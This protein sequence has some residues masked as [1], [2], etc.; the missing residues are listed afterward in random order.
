MKIRQLPLL[1]AALSACG[2]SFAAEPARVTLP[3]FTTAESV[4][5]VCD[6]GLQASRAAIDA[7]ANQPLTGVSAASTLAA[8]DGIAMAIEDFAGPVEIA[9]NVSPVKAVRDA[10]EACS[11]KVAELSNSLFQNVEVYERIRRIDDAKG[12]AAEVRKVAI[13]GFEDAGATLPADKRKRA[14]EILDRIDVLS[15][16]FARNAREKRGSVTFTA[17]EMEGLPASYMAK[18]K[19]DAKGQYTLPM[20]YP[21]YFPFMENAISGDARRRYFIA[22][23]S[24]GGEGN[25]K[26]LDEAA[27]LRLELAALFG[28]KSYAEHVLQR[29]MAGSPEKVL[30]FLARVKDKLAEVEKR[31]LQTLREAKATLLGRS[32]DEVKIER[33]DLPFYTERVRRAKFAVDQNALRRYFPTGATVAWAINLAE[34]MYAVRFVPAE[35][36]KWHEDVRFYDIQ[37]ASGKRIAGAYL[38][39]YPREGKYKHAAVWG[40]RGA[41]TRVGRTPISTMVANF[42]RN[43][44]DYKEA[45]TLL[46]EFGHLLHGTLSKAQYASLAGTNVRRD[47]VEAPSQMF[48]EWT[49]NGETLALIKQYCKDCPTVDAKL[50]ARLDQARR[51]GAGVH[52]TRQHMLASFDMALAGPS[53][54]PA[55]QIWRE[56]ETDSALG[57]VEGTLFPAGFGHMMGGY[58]A[59]YYGYMW[60]EVLALDMAS[61]WKGKLLDKKTGIRY[62]ETILARGGEVPPEQMVREFLGR[63]PSSEPF[64]AEITGQRKR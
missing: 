46:H 5:K 64:F 16:E 4:N 58:A 44:L 35:V 9:Q 55:M 60:A 41:S 19:P 26:L 30:E 13:E 11:Q 7:F 24:V 33:W 17:S 42:D 51:F 61:Q 23:A 50:L 21:A 53:P 56:L 43:G 29:R 12:A 40:L 62:L 57:H 2:A 47:F 63:E 48:E 28:R 18:F 10:A 8:W 59:G 22:F 27:Q 20:D 38:D 34:R 15:I 3:V 49:R 45:K 1:L 54:K 6:D 37:D 14:K 36:P 52:Y 32:V 31:D 25:L 39:L